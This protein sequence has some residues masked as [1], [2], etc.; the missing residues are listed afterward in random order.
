MSSKDMAD[1]YLVSI[2]ANILRPFNL[3]LEIHK[4]GSTI[5]II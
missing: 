5:G 1:I 3:L 2:D 4:P